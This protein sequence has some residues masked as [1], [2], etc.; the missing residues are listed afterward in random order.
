MFLLGQTPHP[1]DLTPAESGPLG[2]RLRGIRCVATI[3]SCTTKG[4]SGGGC[5]GALE[6]PQPGSPHGYLLPASSGRRNK[7]FRA[8]YRLT[9]A[10][11]RC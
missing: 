9:A 1:V 11:A 6:S 8:L 5:G 4:V 7:G 3:L 2:P 10:R